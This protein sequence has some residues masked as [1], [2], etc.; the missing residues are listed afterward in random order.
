M[1]TKNI[2]RNI[3]FSLKKYRSREYK[4]KLVEEQCRLDIRKSSFSHRTINEWNKLSTNCVNAS[5][6]NML[7]N[8]IDKYLR[9]TGYT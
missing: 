5:G 9:T 6:I 3:F 8:K 7:K 2:D 1:V 4:E